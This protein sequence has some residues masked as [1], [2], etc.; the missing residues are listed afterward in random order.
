MEIKELSKE[1]NSQN[2]RSTQH[3]LYAVQETRKIWLSA[4]SEDEHEG[5]EKKED[6]D[7]EDLCSAC[8]KEYREV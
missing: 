1:M 3:P 6:V 8:L 7:E 4:Y 5:A 2:N